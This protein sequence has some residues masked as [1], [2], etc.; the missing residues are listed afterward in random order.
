VAS[1]LAEVGL[2]HVQ[3]LV[4]AS[5]WWL[6]RGGTTPSQREVAEHAGLEPVMTSQVARALQQRGLLARGRSAADSRALQLALTE[7]GRTL[8]HRAVV[9]MDA[10]DREFFDTVDDPEHFVRLLST[11]AQRDFPD[12]AP[13]TSTPS[14]STPSTSTPSTSAASTSTPSTRPTRRTARA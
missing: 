9:L 10:L 7:S 12:E 2:T 11:L 1:R 3:F 13:P 4:L 8:A 14:T 5:V 6:G